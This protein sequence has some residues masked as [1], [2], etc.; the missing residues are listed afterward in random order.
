MGSYWSTLLLLATRSYAF[1]MHIQS[2]TCTQSH[3]HILP[4]NPQ[5]LPTPPKYV[6]RKELS[7][8][9]I[10]QHSLQKTQRVNKVDVVESMLIVVACK[11]QQSSLNMK[12]AANGT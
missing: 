8:S 9:L 12:I 2:H 3:A 11:Q 5:P 10:Q 6:Q 4:H 1:L 7:P